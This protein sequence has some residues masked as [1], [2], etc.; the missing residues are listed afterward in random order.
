MEFI[1]HNATQC[2][3]CKSNELVTY[4]D[5]KICNECM[6]KYVVFRFLGKQIKEGGSY[7]G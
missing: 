1:K 7:N 2:P 5:Y 4:N 3:R 6:A